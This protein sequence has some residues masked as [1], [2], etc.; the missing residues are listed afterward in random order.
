MSGPDVLVLVLL[1]KGLLLTALAA[2]SAYRGDPAS[3]VRLLRGLMVTLLALPALALLGEVA[4]LSLTIT[5]TPTPAADYGNQPLA[6]SQSI[7]AAS[8]GVEAIAKVGPALPWLL[9]IWFIG[10]AA[11]WVRLLLQLRALR[12]IRRAARFHQLRPVSDRSVWIG[13]SDA[14]LSPV[15]FGWRK[16]VVLLPES[17]RQHPDMSVADTEHAVAHEL[18]HV[19]RGDWLWLLVVR[20]AAAAHW[21]N[22]LIPRL[23]RLLAEETEIVCDRSAVTGLTDTAAYAQTLLKALSVSQSAS[24][25]R[26]TPVSPALAMAGTDQW[27]RRI[28]Q[29]YCRETPMQR[30]SL[31][32]TLA[33]GIAL[34]LAV[35]QLSFAQTE[36]PPAPEAAVAPA[37]D[38]VSSPVAPTTPVAADA[39][40]PQ[41]AAAPT[42]A[43]AAASVPAAAPRPSVAPAP[44]AQ[45][46]ARRAEAARRREAVAAERAA[47][48]SDAATLRARAVEMREAEKAQAR[49][50]QAEVRARQEEMR[51]S[52][53]E[54]RLA[55]DEARRAN[56]AALREQE[57]LSRQLEQLQAR[58]A[59][60]EAELAASKE[61][62]SER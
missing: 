5:T 36:P 10:A 57:R 27:R 14:V 21:C 41:A 60:I 3:R 18:A 2:A 15:S 35:G 12:T 49:A 39:P 7:P 54:A 51:A 43:P 24:P 59:E 38:S 40:V 19:A 50:A 8:P 52:R 32:L 16:P 22:P 17:W 48:R 45:A 28:E 11:G 34:P 31:R 26:N 25:L 46:E 55:R 62:D 53:E 44:E 61:R 13:W 37:P 23:S 42:A 47:V 29:L 4:G 9:L 6:H 56:Q 30:F 33:A 58:I 20:L 1:L